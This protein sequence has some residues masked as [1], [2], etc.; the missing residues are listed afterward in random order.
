LLKTATMDFFSLYPHQETAITEMVNLELDHITKRK[1][2]LAMLKEA[3]GSGKTLELLYL[4][5]RTKEIEYQPTPVKINAISHAQTITFK[6][7]T[8]A[9][10]VIVN[11]PVFIQWKNE[12]EKF[13]NLRYHS[14]VDLRQLR[15][16]LAQKN[17][18][19]ITNKYDLILVKSGK[20]TR[21]YEHSNLF[22]TKLIPNFLMAVPFQ[23][24]RVIIDDFNTPK[25]I[26]GLHYPCG[27]ANWLVS[28]TGASSSRRTKDVPYSTPFEIHLSP[29]DLV[30][31]P[32][33]ANDENYIRESI[34]LD[35]PRIK[36]VVFKDQNQTAIS[37]IREFNP[38]I[39]EMVNASAFQELSNRL[40]AQV[41]SIND[42]LFHFINKG[43][44]I[45]KRDVQTHNFIEEIKK[46]IE[47]GKIVLSDSPDA[48]VYSRDD[49]DMRLKPNMCNKM[50][51]WQRIRQLEQTLEASLSNF[52]SKVARLSE[53]VNGECPICM[54]AI[55]GSCVIVKCCS[56]LFCVECSDGMFSSKLRRNETPRCPMCRADINEESLLRLENQSVSELRSGVTLETFED[57]PA[58]FAN[59]AEE[60]AP[61][62][63][64]RL[65]RMEVIEKIV[66]GAGSE[67][68]IHHA[69]E[70]DD[71]D[72]KVPSKKFLMF[73]NYKSSLHEI[74][75]KVK[76]LPVKKLILGG[77]PKQLAEIAKEFEETREDCILFINAMK[78]CQGLN[79]QSA[80]DVIIAHKCDKEI[81]V[82]ATGRAQR[83]G[84][85]SKL[86]VW[87]IFN[88]DEND[89]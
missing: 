61:Q 38:G 49:I 81:M 62:S 2:S 68:P 66:T 47:E 27:V 71:P 13:T 25:I 52:R 31:L 5:S 58:D 89:H 85:Q 33:I 43:N 44:E 67:L 57:I 64:R 80:T 1:T 86:N 9:T 54:D 88:Q 53:N 83:I 35:K 50:A 34:K 36:I 15:S 32:V 87:L 30:G 12:I 65:T 82:Q 6:K 24:K 16:F 37:V 39:M 48:R 19:K 10:L 8:T 29:R 11:P 20:I 41:D 45:F 40:T 79:L 72:E 26:S 84:R 73:S 22:S 70:P 7:I 4:I 60:P 17:L 18:R 14:I 74:S 76:N 55:S 23:W 51:F 3:V 28:A 69:S 46:E 42:L 59:N 56:N 63:S 78:Y 77:T 21:D 75:E